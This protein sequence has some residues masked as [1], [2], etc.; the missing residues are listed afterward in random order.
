MKVLDA[1]MEMVTTLHRERFDNYRKK[2]V[3]NLTKVRVDFVEVY[4]QT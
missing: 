1:C 3:S 2:L 4:L